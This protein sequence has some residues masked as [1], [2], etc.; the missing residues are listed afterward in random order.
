MT[1]NLTTILSSATKTVEIG[2]DKRTIVIGERIN[3][4]GRKQVLAAFQ[5]GDFEIARTD[6]LSQVAAGADMLDVNA[7]V[8]GADE[9]TLLTEVLKTVMAATDVPLCIDT[10]DPQALAAALALYKGKALVN[11]CNG[12]ERSL[13]AVLPI[14]KEYG[15]AV[16]GLC[17]DDDGIPETPEARLKVAARIIERAGKYGIPI[18][19]VVV[20]PLAL[21]MGA[22]SNAGRTA[23]QTVELLVKEFGVNITMGASNISFGMPDRAYINSAFVAMAIH[24]GMTCPITNPL[25]PAVITAILAADLAMG[26]D[27]YGQRWI[28]AYRKRQKEAAA[29]AAS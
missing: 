19:D 7:G 26:H 29:A 28:K 8:P 6:A 21:T 23:L 1:A 15:A 13:K 24:A 11:S 4:T 18:E 17:M 9:P 14:V 25:V 10:A 3:P 16:I 22:D 20:D 12:E 5:A 27:T 2:R